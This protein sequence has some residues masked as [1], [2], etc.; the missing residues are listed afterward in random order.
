LKDINLHSSQPLPHNESDASL[1]ATTCAYCGV[2]CGVDVNV[3]N[4]KPDSLQGTKEHPANFG[5]LCV[6]GTHLLDTLR[7]PEQ[8]NERLST[9][10][11]NGKAVTWNDAT[12]FVADRFSNI[13]EQYGPDAVALYV[14]GQLLTEDYYVA[15]KFMKGYVGSA[16]IDTNSRLCMS[17]AVSAY[18]RAFGEDVV[19]CDYEDLEH[20]DML[21]LVGS[22]AA[23]THPVLFQRVERAKK[24]RPDLKIVVIDP[25]KTASVALADLHLPIRPGSD[26]GI[27]NGLLHFLAEHDGLDNTF[28]EDHTSGF[29][30]AINQAQDWSLSQTAEFCDIEKDGLATFYRWFNDTQRVITFYSMGINQSSSGVDKC[31]SI[32][33]AHLA[34]GKILKN[35]CGPFSITG[36]PNAMGGREVGGLANQLAAHLDLDNSEHRSRIQTFWQSPTIA[37]KAG[38]MAVDLFDAIA[39]GQIKAVWI[40]ATNPIVSL[41][42][43]AKIEAALEACECVVVSDCVSKNDTIH[44]ADAVLPATGWAEKDG[45]VTNSERR[46]SRQR[47][48]VAPYGQAK[49]DWQ[50]L[51]DVAKKMGFSG[52]GYDHQCEIFDEWARMTACVNVG[53]RQLDLHGLT[54]LQQKGYDQLRPVQWPLNDMGESIK[55]FANKQFSTSDGKA[56]FIAI[57]PRL[58]EVPTSTEFPYTMNSGRLRDQWHTMTRTG[59]AAQ[60]SQHSPFSTI[61]VHPQV[62]EELDVLDGDVIQAESAF[63]SVQAY[64]QIT[65]SV[66][67]DSCFMPIH[68]NQQVSAKGSVSRLYSSVVDPISGQPE[69]KQIPVNVSK[70]R[71]TKFVSVFSTQNIDIDESFWVKAR[72]HNTLHYEIATSDEDFSL[73]KWSQSQTENLNDG[74]SAGE[75]ISASNGDVD[76]SVL[77]R[78]KQLLWVSFAFNDRQTQTTLPTEWVTDAFSKALD[79]SLI[80]ALLSA[81]PDEEFLKGRLVCSC[82]KVH[83]KD[84]S[85]AIYA[86]TNS[87]ESLG[88]SLKCGTNCGSC[89]SELQQ[90]INNTDSEANAQQRIPSRRVS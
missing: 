69:S 53:E 61:M 18:K 31:N 71:Y 32:I 46:I 7:T 56:K 83:E 37:E 9:P 21:V 52:F 33:N 26:A 4:G 60:L 86:G 72:R 24:Q 20:T 12:S 44:Y 35:G 63:G 43:R 28:I 73:H 57:Q 3:V 5:R 6:K 50:I 40:I 89:K 2:G 38:K 11:V 48:F 42:N 66:R 84:I 1:I 87:V 41:P 25:R 15:N 62:A 74:T 58:P 59:R 78:E 85:D 47:G 64:A 51:C 55:P 81:E 13:I 16:N 10:M 27:F 49:H 75:W 36:Q 23:W 88:A 29:G 65:D 80:T 22:N 19:P 77:M 82:F 67:K 17:S 76:V 79:F 39:D 70:T 34:S 45:T 90:M 30:E 14:S 8:E 68:F 54:G